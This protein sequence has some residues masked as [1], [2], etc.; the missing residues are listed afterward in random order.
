M[1]LEAES[2]K[3]LTTGTAI[4]QCDARHS[5]ADAVLNAEQVDLKRRR[6]HAVPG[7]GR[8]TQGGQH[9]RAR[10]PYGRDGLRAA[11]V[12][13]AARAG[14]LEGGRRAR[15]QARRCA[16]THARRE[17]RAAERRE[18]GARAQ[19]VCG[20]AR[21]RG[22]FSRLNPS[23]PNVSL[24]RKLSHFRSGRMQMDAV[25][26]YGACSTPPTP[27]PPPAERGSMA[28][29]DVEAWRPRPQDHTPALTTA[30]LPPP[31]TPSPRRRRSRRR[32]RRRIS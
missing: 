27:P 18:H 26:C 4:T 23:G 24:S 19:K 6:R 12:H 15:G 21:A 20:G 13:L 17:R 3:W 16:C 29:G 5:E 1:S 30:Y 7:R 25:R 10:T 32:S 31:A 2:H 11:G 28:G 8:G 9:C 14:A 22:F